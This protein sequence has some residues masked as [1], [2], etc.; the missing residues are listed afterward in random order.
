MG[1]L[2][3]R[4]ILEAMSRGYR[5]EK[6]IVKIVPPSGDVRCIAFSDVI[7]QDADDVDQTPEL[8][9]A[10]RVAGN[11]WRRLNIEYGP[12]SNVRR[13]AILWCMPNPTK[14]DRIEHLGFA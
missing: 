4:G 1:S 11:S 3:G 7:G 8:E 14:C 13:V 6:P 2:L 5:Q 12:I 9:R 10:D